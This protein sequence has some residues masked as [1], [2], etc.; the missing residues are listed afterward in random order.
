M[1]PDAIRH[2][3]YKY[4][5]AVIDALTTFV[6]C[7]LLK[8]RTGREVTRAVQVLSQFKVKPKNLLTDM[9]NDF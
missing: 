9:E 5:L 7:E 6:W 3:R 4:A 2:K 1:I 8:N